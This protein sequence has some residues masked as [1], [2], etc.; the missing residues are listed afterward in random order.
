M[1]W[2]ENQLKA[3]VRRYKGWAAEALRELNYDVK[4][5]PDP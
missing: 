5:P 4:P 1:R 3:A 2:R